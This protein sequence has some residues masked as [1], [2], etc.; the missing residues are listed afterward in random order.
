MDIHLPLTTIKNFETIILEQ[1]KQLIKE[2][3]IWKGWNCEELT[4]EFLSEKLS[5]NLMESN[6]NLET[7]T[8]TI[9]IHEGNKYLLESISDNVYTLDGNYIGKKY[10]NF[11]DEE[12]E[13]D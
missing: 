8:R 3:C 7:R 6:S 1:N 11:I 5:F 4:K 12:A 10:D 13:E 2:I 9:W